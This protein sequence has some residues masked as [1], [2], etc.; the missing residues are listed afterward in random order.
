[1]DNVWF[2]TSCVHLLVY[3]ED[4]FIYRENVMIWVTC[5]KLAMFWE[6]KNI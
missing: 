3:V 2:Y 5:K 6:H 4:Y 1:M